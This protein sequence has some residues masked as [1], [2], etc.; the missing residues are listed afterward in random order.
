M[1]P[2]HRQWTCT[3]DQ[4]RASEERLVSEIASHV[5][6]TSGEVVRV[7]ASDW[8]FEALKL[9]L[10]V[11]TDVKADRAAP[12]SARF[13]V[14]VTVG[15]PAVTATFELKKVGKV[16]VTEPVTETITIG[17]QV[18]ARKNLRNVTGLTQAT[19]ITQFHDLCDLAVA[20]YF[21]TTAGD[22]LY[23]KFVDLGLLLPSTQFKVPTPTELR[24]L[25]DHYDNLNLNSAAERSAAMVSELEITSGGF[26]SNDGR[27][28]ILSS[29]QIA[30]WADGWDSVLLILPSGSSVYGGR[31][32]FSRLGLSVRLIQAA[33]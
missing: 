25:V 26:I 24:G 11:G 21:E 30:W 28:S 3:S 22:V 23:N 14:R 19:S 32:V 16:T 10:P 6:T 27:L 13:D 20:A 29:D 18:W 33:A 1:G 9:R 2:Q 8:F 5:R 7:V 12:L 15:A 17:T 31:G 4:A